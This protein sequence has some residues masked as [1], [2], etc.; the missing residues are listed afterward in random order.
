M[1]TNLLKLILASA[2]LSAAVPS[3]ASSSAN[4]PSAVQCRGTDSIIQKR[5]R[6]ARGR[7]T[8]VVRDT[9]RLCT[10]H[11]YKLRAREGQ[12]MSL[13]LATGKRTSMTLRAPDGEALLDGG[14]DF[15]GSL[16]S[17]GEYTIEIGTDATA[18]YTLEVAIR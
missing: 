2:V 11:E 12:T 3:F 15:E 18:R 9:V 6:F 1:R 10:G 5:I 4:V 7:T 17:T 8:A 14:N 16:P 13:H